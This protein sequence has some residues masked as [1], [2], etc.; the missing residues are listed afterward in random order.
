MSPRVNH[1]NRFFVLPVSTYIIV[2][3]LTST[4]A[5]LVYQSQLQT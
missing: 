5:L 2:Q 4:T 3:A 1:N